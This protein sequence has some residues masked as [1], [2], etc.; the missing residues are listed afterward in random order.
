MNLRIKSVRQALGMNQ[1][2]FGQRLGI[3][4]PGVSKI[5]SGERS[6]STQVILAICREFRVD[7]IWL[8]T[9]EGPMFRPMSRSDE[10][11]AFFGNIQSRIPDFRVRLISVMSELTDEEWE[12][13]ERKAR[14]LFVETQETQKGEP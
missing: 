11:A 3:T 12:Y 1:R 8:R 14:K 9:G 2:D 13:L 4:A 10:L 6:P 5:E 7:E